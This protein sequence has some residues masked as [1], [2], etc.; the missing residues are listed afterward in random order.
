V[1]DEDGVK[2]IGGETGPREPPLDFL[3][4]ETAVQQHA[5]CARTAACFYDQRIAL[6]A[7]AEARKAHGRFS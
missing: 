1:G 3:C 7:A 5:R 4:G 6:T 2:G